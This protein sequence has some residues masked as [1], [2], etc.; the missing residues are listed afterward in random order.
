MCIII[1]G[2]ILPADFVLAPA[3]EQISEHDKAVHFA[4]Y[5][6]LGLLAHFAFDASRRLSAA[7]SAVV[8]GGLLEVLQFFFPP[9]QPEILDFIANGL[10][11]LFGFLLGN[12]VRSGKKVI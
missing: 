10:G 11:V 2:S 4:A 12:R 3:A 6:I 5:A 8:L 9:R 7:W 1:L